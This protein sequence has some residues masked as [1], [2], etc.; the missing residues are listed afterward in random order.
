MQWDRLKERSWTPS[1]GSQSVPNQAFDVTA[2]ETAT[3]KK[4]KLFPTIY[5]ILQ[6]YFLRPV[7]VFLPEIQ[8]RKFSMPRFRSMH[9]GA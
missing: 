3:S 9:F 6:S 1:K 4:L 5:L 8:V 2:R 7:L